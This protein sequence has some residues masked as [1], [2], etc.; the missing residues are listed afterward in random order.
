MIWFLLI[1][2]LNSLGLIALASGMSKHQK[3]FF[4]R[5][6]S[7][8]ASLI[9]KITGWS[10]LVFSLI[11]CLL[12]SNISIRIN[13]W[14]GALTFAALFTAWCLSYFAHH[15]KKLVMGCIAIFIMCIFPQFF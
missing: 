2:S 10:L 15:M 12:H 1:W 8:T 4:S 13:Y 14:L 9:A 7:P 3:Q 5:E 6:L 11:S